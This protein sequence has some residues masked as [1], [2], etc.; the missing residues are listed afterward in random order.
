M[1]SGLTQTVQ[2]NELEDYANAGYEFL[3]VRTPSE[4]ERGTIPNSKN[5]SVDDL[6]TRYKE[7]SKKNVIVNCQVGQR[8]HTATLLLNELGFNAKN[9]DGGYLTWKNSPANP[10]RKK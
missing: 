8:G 4:F 2:W 3:D 5:I 1:I 10:G 6:R 9:L 7:I